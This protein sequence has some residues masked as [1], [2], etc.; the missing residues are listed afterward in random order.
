MPT[1][2]VVSPRPIQ[3]YTRHKDSTNRT[4]LRPKK[5]SN[6]HGHRPGH[7]H[8][9]NV[10][11]KCDQMPAA[12]PYRA[13]NFNTV[14][15]LARARSCG[16]R[17]SMRPVAPRVKYHGPQVVTIRKKVPL[18]VVDLGI[19][20]LAC[21]SSSPDSSTPQLEFYTVDAWMWCASVCAFSAA[22]CASE[23]QSINRPAILSGSRS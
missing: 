9:C 18:I 15:A 6:N 19:P 10:Q 2:F 1:K 17:F 3:K 14:A 21:F 11:K 16:F 8:S 22:G 13:S 23:S 12:S 4:G 7:L 20:H 5:S